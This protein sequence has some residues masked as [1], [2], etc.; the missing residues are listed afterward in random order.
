LKSGA[1]LYLRELVL[2]QAIPSENPRYK[3]LPTI[4]SLPF[5][6]PAWIFGHPKRGVEKA[7]ET[8]RSSREGEDSR[9]VDGG[10]GSQAFV[11]DGPG[12]RTCALGGSTLVV[13]MAS[14][15]PGR[16][17]GLFFGPFLAGT[18]AESKEARSQSIWSAS[19]RR[20]SRACT[21][22]CHTPASCHSLRRRQ[23]VTPLP[24]PI[25][26]GS[27][28]QGMPLFSTKTM[29]VR[30]ARSSR[31]GLPPWGLGDSSGKSGSTISQSS[32][33]TNSLAISLTYPSMAVL[34]GSLRVVESRSAVLYDSNSVSTS[35][36][37]AAS[38]RLPCGTCL[39]TIMAESE[40]G[41]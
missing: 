2:A 18:L 32:S 22:R 27:I 39:F 31:R 19:P 11:S 4:S 14:T 9:G 15:P 26:L 35:R 37:T 7:P 6:Q 34:K 12:R 25:S 23:Q 41:N 8:S 10:R 17:S 30:A 40:K 28:S 3:H 36:T 38:L 1:K 5:E 29:P 33:L 21:R 13:V 16:D 24:Q 20:S